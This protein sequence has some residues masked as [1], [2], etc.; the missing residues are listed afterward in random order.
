MRPKDSQRTFHCGSLTTP[1]NTGSPSNVSSTSS[2][3][4]AERRTG[5]GAAGLPVAA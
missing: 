2:I 1:T 5:I 3:A 4:Q